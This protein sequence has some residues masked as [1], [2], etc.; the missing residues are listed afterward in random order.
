MIT[1]RR[2]RF[3]ALGCLLLTASI[4]L[5]APSVSAQTPLPGCISAGTPVPGNPASTPT[6]EAAGIEID[7]NLA[8]TYLQASLAESIV[9]FATIASEGVDSPDLATVLL[10]QGLD[11]E[12]DVSTLRPLLPAGEP[13]ALD[14]LLAV[15]DA[16]RQEL[17][18]LAGQGGSVDFGAGPWIAALCSTE[19]AGD[20]IIANASI[21]LSQQ[22]I[23]LAQVAVAAGSPE[24]Q[25]MGR[26]IIDRESARI[27]VVLA[28]LAGASPM[29]SPGATPGG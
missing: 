3:A 19:D 22:Q 1:E 7:A 24:S 8:W 25:A 12:N 13:I 26:A 18:L 5:F 4:G 14:A 10:Q 2:W 6:P 23:D 15:A 11:A 16:T 21:D 20:T 9:G 27:S 28:F 17:D 29:A